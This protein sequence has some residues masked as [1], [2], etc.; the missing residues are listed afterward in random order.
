LWPHEAAANGPAGQV[1]GPVVSPVEDACGQAVWCGQGAITLL[2]IEG[3]DGRVLKGRALSDQRWTGST[4][5]D[6]A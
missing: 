3:Q 5:V 2:E 4:W 6:D 1:I